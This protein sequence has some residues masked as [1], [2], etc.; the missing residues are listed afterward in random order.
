[1]R[2]NLQANARMHVICSLA[3]SAG[4]AAWTEVA[5]F[6]VERRCGGAHAERGRRW[7]TSRKD[8]VHE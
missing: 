2:I 4:E 7:I 1:M 6:G 3:E 8:K 5:T